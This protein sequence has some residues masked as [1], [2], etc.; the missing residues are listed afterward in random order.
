MTLLKANSVAYVNCDVGVSGNWTFNPSGTP[1][2]KALVHEVAKMVD[3]PRK[4][5]S[6]V[7]D[8]FNA[9]TIW[10][11]MVLRRGLAENEGKAFIFYD[12]TYLTYIF[13]AL[14]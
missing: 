12:C 8:E 2:M 6:A 11:N 1:N 4:G 13:Q 10:D 14:L 5:D 7:P 3:N 9:D